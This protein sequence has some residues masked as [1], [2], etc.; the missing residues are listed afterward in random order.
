MTQIHWIHHITALQTSHYNRDCFLQ[1]KPD[2]ARPVAIL[3]K[4]KLL[5][6]DMVLN[7]FYAERVYTFF[8]ASP[9]LDN[10]IDHNLPWLLHKSL[11]D[12]LR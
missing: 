11:L 7:L 6:N 3:M 5:N 12:K 4:M 10:L 1:S 8:V 2:H 9:Q